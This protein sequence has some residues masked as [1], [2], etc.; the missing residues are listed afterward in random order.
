MWGLYDLSQAAKNSMQKA[1]LF[2][3]YMNARKRHE[4]RLSS[5]MGKKA[6]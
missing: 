5:F 3:A 1:Q 6:V 2:C 4:R